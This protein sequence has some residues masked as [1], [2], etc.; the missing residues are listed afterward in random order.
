MFNPDQLA[1]HCSLL[2]SDK[3]YL[4]STPNDNKDST[5]NNCYCQTWCILRYAFVIN[6]FGFLDFAGTCIYMLTCT[7]SKCFCVLAVNC[8]F[9]GLIILIFILYSPTRN[10]FLGHSVTETCIVEYF[11]RKERKHVGWCTVLIYKCTE[12]WFNI[13]KQKICPQESISNGHAT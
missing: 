10:M 11:C 1:C 5:W 2:K 8:L 3:K 12:V 7:F 9:W 13:M 6:R 4:N